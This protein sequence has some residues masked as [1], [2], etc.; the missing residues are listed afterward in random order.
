ML[1]KRAQALS[2]IALFAVIV[3][4]FIVSVVIIN[5]TNKVLTPFSDSI[6]NV[7]TEAASNVDY[8]Q[9]SFNRWWDWAVILLFFLNVI[10]LFITAFL[11]DV[12]PA[13]LIIYV[14]A[15][16]FL[17]TFG[18]SVMGA[19]QDIW[20]VTDFSSGVANMPITN[21]LMNNFSIVLLGI[22]VLSGII[23]YA[24]FKFG[25]GGAV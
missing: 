3:G 22:A 5:I 25:S 19:V 6:E 24:K 14:L 21:W 18:I 15:L 4:I 13:F 9:S 23:M 7:S 12:H 20:G 10:L 11:V 1:N 17:F 8:I 2:I 16:A